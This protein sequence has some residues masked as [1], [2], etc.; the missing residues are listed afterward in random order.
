MPIFEYVCGGC[1]TK[2]E[3]LSL[4]TDN[5][6]PYCPE[7]GSDEATEVPSVFNILHGEESFDTIL[8]VER[9]LR[10]GLGL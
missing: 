1:N 8:E 7:C 9:I 4:K 10:M 5:Q 2:F 3:H 6:S